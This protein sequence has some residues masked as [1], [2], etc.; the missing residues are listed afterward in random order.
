MSFITG[1]RLQLPWVFFRPAFFQNCD[2][3]LLRGNV[4]ILLQYEAR[5]QLEFYLNLCTLTK[6]IIDQNAH[7]DAPFYRWWF[8]G[9]CVSCVRPWG[10]I[11]SDFSDLFF[12]SVASKATFLYSNWSYTTAPNDLFQ[13]GLKCA[14]LLRLQYFLPAGIANLWPSSHAKVAWT[15]WCLALENPF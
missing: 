6:Y 15:A 7:C 10:L 5:W 1:L 12:S 13:C 4:I 2:V 11:L 9:S 3:S 14:F 8:M